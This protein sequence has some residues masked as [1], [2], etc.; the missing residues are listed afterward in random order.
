MQFIIYFMLIGVVNSY[1]V[2]RINSEFL[3]N[4]KKVIDYHIPKWVYTEVFD[5]NKKLSEN[6]KLIEKDIDM[7][8]RKKENSTETFPN[9]GEVPW[10][11]TL[12]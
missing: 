6:F 12:Q 3:K 2:N 10:T 1:G 5:Y 9:V 7:L 8:M 4:Q 11:D